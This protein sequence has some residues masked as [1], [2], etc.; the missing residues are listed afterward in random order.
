M[1]RLMFQS[2]QKADQHALHWQQ[3]PPPRHARCDQDATQHNRPE[4]PHQ[5]PQPCGIGFFNQC[6]FGRGWQTSQKGFVIHIS[7][8]SLADQSLVRP[9]RIPQTENRG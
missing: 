2:E 4:M 8:V 5:M 7:V 6:G 3:D 9:V 1:R